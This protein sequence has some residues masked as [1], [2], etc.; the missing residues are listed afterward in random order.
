MSARAKGLRPRYPVYT[1]G[2]RVPWGDL[3][4][5]G[6][7]GPPDMRPSE[8]NPHYSVYGGAYGRPLAGDEEVDDDPCG[9]LFVTCKSRSWAAAEMKYP[10]D[11]EAR[12]AFYLRELSAC[13]NAVECDPEVPAEIRRQWWNQNGYWAIPTTVGLGVLALGGIGYGLYRMTK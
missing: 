6:A 11:A 5:P 3:P 9:L 13:P 8:L 12:R 2:N 1:S 10:D 7:F 4:P